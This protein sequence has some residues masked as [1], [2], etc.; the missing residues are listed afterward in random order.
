MSIEGVR[1]PNKTVWKNLMVAKQAFETI[2]DVLKW[3]AQCAFRG[4]F[5]EIARIVFDA[6][7]KLI[8]WIE[9][10]SIDEVKTIAFTFDSDRVI[11]NYTL[12]YAN[13]PGY[14]RVFPR[15]DGPDSFPHG[16]AADP[17]QR[18]QLLNLLKTLKEQHPNLSKE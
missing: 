15:Y 4:D 9:G 7:G 11:R 16:F 5:E 14:F 12:G 1:I 2:D 18:D 10:E 8:F 13:S 3:I 17:E 6:D